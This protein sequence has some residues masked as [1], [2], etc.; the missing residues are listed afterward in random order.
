MKVVIQRVL[1]A[2][3]KVNGEIIG[4]IGKG[5]VVLVGI[6]QDDNFVDLE[7]ISGKLK[8]IRIFNDEFGRMN[9]NLN[10]TKS[11]IMV[12]SQFTLLASVKKGNR[13]SFLDAA[14]P[15]KAKELFDVFVEKFEYEGTSK[16]VKGLFGA[17]MK[18]NLTNDG[19]VTIILDSKKRE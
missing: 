13:P 14:E 5:M 1:E 8:S 19:P 6:H 18:I 17:D 9:L 3:L 12:I 15:K 10:Q 11:D 4:T 2:G 7:W 16:L